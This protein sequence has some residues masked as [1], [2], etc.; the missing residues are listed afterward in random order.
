MLTAIWVRSGF[1]AVR[2]YSFWQRIAKQDVEKL[3]RLLAKYVTATT[4]SRM[5]G[6]H[7]S[8]VPNL[9]RRGEIRSITVGDNFPVRLYLRS[10][11]EALR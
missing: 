11:V 9:E 2:Q 1:I 6:M 4:A 8:H 10:D 3:E 7:R 5:L